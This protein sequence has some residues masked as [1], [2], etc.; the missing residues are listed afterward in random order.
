ME[1]AGEFSDLL[2]NGWTTTGSLNVS[3]GA[4]RAVVLPGGEV[5]VHGG[6]TGSGANYANLESAELYSP[7]TGSWT[8][9]GSTFY[10]R[11]GHTLIL[12][13]NGKVLAAGGTR[14]AG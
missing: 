3:R 5:L 9:T 4:H 12:L 2:I 7:I 11:N 10:Q 1:R 8:M 13:P 6:Y 14:P